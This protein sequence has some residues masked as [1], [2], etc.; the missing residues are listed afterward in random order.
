MAVDGAVALDIGV[1]EAEARWAGS[2][3]AALEGA[4]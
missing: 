1:D 4:A 2:L 3:A